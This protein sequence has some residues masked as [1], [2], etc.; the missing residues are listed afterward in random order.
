MSERLVERD[1]RRTTRPD[2]RDYFDWTTPNLDVVANPTDPIVT[3]VSSETAQLAQALG[4]AIQ[5]LESYKRYKD[6]KNKYDYQEGY[7]A[8]QKGGAKPTKEE[9]RTNAYLR[10]W[11]EMNGEALAIEFEKEATNLTSDLKDKD[12]I[13]FKDAYAELFQKY[14]NQLGTDNET[15]GFLSRFNEIDYKIQ[16]TYNEHQ[17]A[18]QKQ[19][20]YEKLNG[21]FYDDLVLNIT[22]LLEVGSLSEFANDPFAYQKYAEDPE[23]FKE[24][25]APKLREY[26]DKAFE[27]Y[28]DTLA[29]TKREISALFLENVASLA[30]KY[31]IP[32]LLAYAYLKDKRNIS[33][34]DNAELKQFV[35]AS[36]A[37]AQNNFSTK[38]RQINSEINR[39]KEEYVTRSHNEYTAKIMLLQPNN[40]E[41]AR[42]L[43]DEILADDLLMGDSKTPVLINSL[44]EIL[45]GSGHPVNSK[46][47]VYDEIQQKLLTESLTKDDLLKFKYSLS[48]KDYEGFWSD[49]QEQTRREKA[50]R[51]ALGMTAAEAYKRR[52]NSVIRI[53]E[54]QLNAI[55][56]LSIAWAIG[57]GRAAEL[58][59][60][61]HYDIYLAEQEK[62]FLSP[63]ELDKIIDVYRKEAA[64][65][66]AETEEA[67][68]RK[69]QEQEQGNKK[70][71]KSKDK[72]KQEDSIEVPPGYIK[73]DRVDPITKQPVYLKP[74]G[75][76]VILG[77]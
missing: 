25:I 72:K 29:L 71:K 19:L 22:Q 1:K 16:T 15:R 2:S 32:D 57:K 76:Y 14:V 45:E 56:N 36:Y 38:L 42:K 54:N 12:P 52:K 65:Y 74:D 31:A 7:Q 24:K 67:I 63:E 44:E 59:N 30:K 49:L 77:D 51:E 75:T 66:Q 47:E 50:R 3:P 8:R 40:Q 27:K 58:T 39:R 43:L 53:I 33:I 60:H 9:K 4:V 34:Y 11:E 28:E 48:Q 68:E 41:E 10:G 21:I 23:A 13:T 35:D 6:V 70:K 61:L 69:K 64:L 18:Y 26:L 20:K 37:A 62:G 46:P 5:G 55:D 17:Q 73:T